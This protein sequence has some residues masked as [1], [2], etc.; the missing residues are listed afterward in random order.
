VVG[1]EREEPA[2]HLA[3]FG[4]RTIG[5]AHLRAAP[6]E[7]PADTVAQLLSSGLPSVL[8][9]RLAPVLVSNDD[10]LHVLRAQ[11]VERAGSFMQKENVFGH[12]CLLSS[13]KRTAP[14]R[15][16]IIEA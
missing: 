4:V 10:L 11:M 8:G 16:D 1:D 12:F 3:S 7:N 14:L 15:I 13:Q 6:F 2:D 9:E 5:D